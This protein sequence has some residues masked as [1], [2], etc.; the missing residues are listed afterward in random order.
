MNQKPEETPPNPEPLDID[1][2][3]IEPT[4]PGETEAFEVPPEAGEPTTGS[5][6]GPE[7]FA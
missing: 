2:E 7:A 5:G 6:L 3:S 4:P 1:F